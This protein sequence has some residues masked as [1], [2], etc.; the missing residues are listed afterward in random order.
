ME[1]ILISEAIERLGSSRA[2]V[3][4]HIRKLKIKTVKRGKA[5]LS[6]SQYSEYL[7]G[8]KKHS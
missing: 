5:F 2:T 6:S 4:K 8:L 1:K 3:Y 7:K